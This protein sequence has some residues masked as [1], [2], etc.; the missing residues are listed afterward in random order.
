[1]KSNTNRQTL[2]NQLFHTWLAI[3]SVRAFMF[4]Y[5]EIDPK[6]NLTG[7]TEW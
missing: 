1:M 6:Q 5:N 3:S 4:G 2:S 7:D